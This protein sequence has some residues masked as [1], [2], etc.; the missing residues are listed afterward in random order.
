MREDKNMLYTYSSSHGQMALRL[1]SSLGFVCNC[2]PSPMHGKNE[3]LGHS[4][5]VGGVPLFLMQ[6]VLFVTFV[7]GFLFLLFRV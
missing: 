4:I 1:L 2:A 7:S 5:L 6:K 3:K